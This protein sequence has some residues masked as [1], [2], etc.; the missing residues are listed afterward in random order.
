[1]PLEI[2]DDWISEA[3]I[4]RATGASPRN[5][6]QWR[7]HG[8]VVGKRRSLGRGQGTTACFYPADTASL[9]QRLYEL[10]RIVR[11]A[12][13]W[14]WQL[15]LEGFS[16]DIRKSAMKRLHETIKLTEGVGPAGVASAALKA[17]K[18]RPGS[19][20][21]ARFFFDRVRKSAD[22]E[23]F[24]LY[25]GATFAGHVQQASIHNADPPI[26]D[27]GLKLMGI[28]RSRLAPPKA[29]LDMLSTYWYH[30]ILA[31]ANQHE[32]EQARRDWQAVD[33]ILDALKA[34]DWDA[35]GRE[36]EAKIQA[37]TKSRPEPP[38]KRQRR[39]RRRRPHARPAIVD[40]ALQGLS[41]L[42]ARPYLLALFVGLRRSSP[43]NSNNCSQAIALA[44]SLLSSLPRQ[45]SDSA[46]PEPHL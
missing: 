20:N 45:T 4:I 9:V 6:A 15:W 44:E 12:D 10:Q 36:L 40:T 13:R 42:D 18:A 31:T 27:I 11:D 21:P 8:I 32:I 43:E 7:S 29:N 28:P 46:P 34:T 5:L 14:V 35:A 16:T 30:Q 39:A 19:I 22:R 17:A 38:S 33:R 24:A 37:L 25:I 2:A 23:A 41:R 1:M 3:E 26:F